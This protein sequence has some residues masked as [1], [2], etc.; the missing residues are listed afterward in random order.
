MAAE[1]TRSGTMRRNRIIAIVA[2]IITM[3]AIVLSFASGYLGLGWEWLRP[4][5]ELLLLAELVGLIVLER[6]QLFEPVSDK[7]HSIDARV[8]Q[9]SEAVGLAD[10]PAMGTALA[11]LNQRVGAAGQV[12]AYLGT[13]EVLR[14][15]TRL[16]REAS[17]GSRE[18]PQMLRMGLFAGR[19]LFDDPRAIG[20]ELEKWNMLLAEHY[21]VPSSPPDSPAHTCAFR[22]IVAFADAEALDFALSAV[23]PTLIDPNVLNVEVKILLRAQPEGLLSP[24]LIT[25]RAVLLSYDDETSSYRWGVVLEGRQYVTLFARWFDDRWAAIPDS[26]LVYSRSGLNQAATA[27]VRKE[28]ETAAAGREANPP[29]SS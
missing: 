19:N 18:G 7:V 20:D 17:I 28:L 13:R 27:R 29:G 24:A 22:V 15:R 8:A 25:D 26:Y 10:L 11:Q 14:V 2:G 12:A 4:A 5:G 21:L 9:I 16:L 3:T 1:P 6:Y 23:R